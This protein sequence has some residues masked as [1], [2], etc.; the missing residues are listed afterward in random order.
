MSCRFFATGLLLLLLASCA[1]ESRL[2]ANLPLPEPSA[3]ALTASFSQLITASY[4]GREQP[5][6][7]Q[8]ELSPEKL[9]VVIMH[10]SGVRLLSASYDG[11]KI[12]TSSLP[13]PG[14]PVTPE[15]VL[16]DIMMA[17]WPATSWQPLLLPRK[18]Y[19]VD[20]KDQRKLLT[21]EGELIYQI[22]YQGKATDPWYRT[23]TLHNLRYGYQLQITPLDNA[24]K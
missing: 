1:T 11:E 5:L 21:R 24:K 19:L 3:A 20:T 18:Q 16:N 4:D 17:Y 9:V 23:L 13:L 6:L 2:P 15:R 12:V 10:P 14:V 7:A 22:D 8:L